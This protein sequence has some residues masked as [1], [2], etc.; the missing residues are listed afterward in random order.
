MALDTVIVGGGQSGLAAGYYLGRAGLS[1]VIL[2]RSQRIGDVWR[3]RWDSLTLFT[4][5]AFSSLPGL[6]FPAPPDHLPSKDEVADYLERYANQFNLPVQ[7]G[8]DVIGLNGVDG[9]YRV[10]LVN[11]ETFEAATVI[12]ATGPFQVPAIPPFAGKLGPHVFQVHSSNYRN[13]AQLRDGPTLVVGA[14]ASGLQIAEELAATRRVCLSVSG[15]PSPYIPRPLLGKD[16]FWWFSKTGFVSISIET[17]IGRWLAH[18]QEPLVGTSARRLRQELGVQFLGRTIDAVGDTITF[19]NGETISVS[20]VVWATGFRSD[21]GWIHLPVVDSGGRPIHR[22]GGTSALGV[23]FLGADVAAHQR[24][25]V[26]RMGRPGCE[27]HRAPSRR[28]CAL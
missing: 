19:A 13:P 23:Y 22:R 21:F 16:P 12:V 4:P 14:Q 1:F 18:R 6:P 27:V 25:G 11:G 8:C 9:R 10:S 24:V 3:R 7:L 28:Q 5:A 20:N 17:P 26:D 2:E 15:R